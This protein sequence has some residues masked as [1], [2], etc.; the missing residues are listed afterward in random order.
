MAKTRPFRQIVSD[1]REYLS[2]A[3]PLE[4]LHLLRGHEATG[5][6]WETRNLFVDWR[7]FLDAWSAKQNPAK[8]G[9]R[10]IA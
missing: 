1:W 9:V 6:P 10:G 2:E 8:Y 5:G 3:S 7:R 4:D